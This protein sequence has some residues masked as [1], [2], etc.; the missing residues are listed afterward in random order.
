MKPLSPGPARVL[1]AIIDLQARREHVTLRS[2]G[3]ECGITSTSTIHL[4]IRALNRTGLISVG[5]QPRYAYV[6]MPEGH[7]AANE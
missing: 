2:I 4:H 7:D 6:V 5:P 1:K 3:R